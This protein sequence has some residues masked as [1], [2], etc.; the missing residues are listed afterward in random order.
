MTT[1]MGNSART[2]RDS[3]P[4]GMMLYWKNIYSNTCVKRPLSKRQKIGLQDKLSLNAGQKYCRISYHLSFKSLFCLFLSGRFTQF[5]LY[6]TKLLATP[7][8][9]SA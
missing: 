8:G 7:Q 2:F 4:L 3:T 9:H 1:I 6:I 5:Y